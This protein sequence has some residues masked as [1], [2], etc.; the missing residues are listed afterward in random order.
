MSFPSCLTI[1]GCTISTSLVARKR[2]FSTERREMVHRVVSSERVSAP[3]GGARTLENLVYFPTLPKP[4]RMSA[5]HIGRIEGSR[6][7]KKTLTTRDKAQLSRR[8]KI[9]K[10][11]R[12]R[13]PACPGQSLDQPNWTL[14]LN[15]IQSQ[16][17]SWDG[18]INGAL[19][20]NYP[21]RMS[22]GFG[23]TSYFV[24]ACA[25]TGEATFRL[26]RSGTLDADPKTR[27]SPITGLFG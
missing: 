21:R 17:V 11:F 5:R 18:G 8:K 6:G 16:S 7:Q 4:G 10:L 19:V 9:T 26:E 3:A 23:S 22:L 24:T 27:T 1:T 15:S 2:A 25:A 12:K 14:T 20:L 13:R